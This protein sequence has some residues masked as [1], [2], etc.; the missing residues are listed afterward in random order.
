M[1]AFAEFWAEVVVK[2]SVCSPSTPSSNPA[3]VYSFFL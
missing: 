3:E 2:R 1:K